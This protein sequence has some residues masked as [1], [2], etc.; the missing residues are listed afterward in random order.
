[1]SGLGWSVL[2][3]ELVGFGARREAVAGSRVVARGFVT[4]AGDNSSPLPDPLVP[5]ARRTPVG[6]AP[7]EHSG[8]APRLEVLG[9][10]DNYI[11]RQRSAY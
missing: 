3:W 2:A 9:Y 10:T 8:Y 7:C 6:D 5:A 11:V 1:M 4:E